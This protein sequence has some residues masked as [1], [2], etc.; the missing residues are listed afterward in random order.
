[1][2]TNCA[3]PDTTQ[4]AM[5]P[6][7]FEGLI[8][9]RFQ[10]N[11]AT[12]FANAAR[13]SVDT[14]GRWMPWCTPS[15]S[16]QDALAWFKQCRA[17]ARSETGYELGVFS[18]QTGEF[19]GGVALNAIHHQ[20]LFCNL[21]YWVKQSAQRK[22][23]ALRA[24][25]ALVP[26]AFHVLGMQRVEIVIATGNTA[27]EAIARNYGAHFEGIARNRLQLHGVAVSASIFSIVP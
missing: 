15:F 26:H 16:K 2:L 4:P 7:T 27:S 10:N 6:I 17:S 11:D 14:V 18:Q 20:N 9:R 19:L 21:G 23:V 12:A 5:S 3:D 1:M 8:L 25:R 24:V 13:E 22:G